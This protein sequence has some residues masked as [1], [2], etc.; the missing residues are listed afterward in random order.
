MTN[1]NIKIEIFAEIDDLENINT[2]VYDENGDEID[3]IENF[4]FEEY[5]ELW[6]DEDEEKL[7]WREVLDYIPTGKAGNIAERILEQRMDFSLLSKDTEKYFD[8]DEQM[9]SSEEDIH[10]IFNE[11]TGLV[12]FYFNPEEIGMCDQ[13]IFADGKFLSE[14]LKSL[15]EFRSSSE[16]DEEADREELM[17]KVLIDFKKEYTFKEFF[18]LLFNELYHEQGYSIVY[19]E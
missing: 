13:T 15:I 17:F 4:D 16:R 8:N 6:L 3:A 5:D 14:N 1:E 12:C 10:D 2:R 18:I 7:K 19:H 9:S 11:T